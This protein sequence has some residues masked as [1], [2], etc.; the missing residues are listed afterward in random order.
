MA[1]FYEHLAASRRTEGCWPWAGG[2]HKLGYGHASIPGPPRKKGMAHRM[3]Y[4]Y[5]V[6]PI[7]PGMT[8]DHLCYNRGCVNPAHMRL[9]SQSENVRSRCTA[10]SASVRSGCSHERQTNERGN[11]IPCA[12]CSGASLERYRERYPDWKARNR[13]AS[14]KYKAKLKCGTVKINEPRPRISR[15]TKGVPLHGEVIRS[16]VRGELLDGKGL[17]N[18]FDFEELASG[19]ELGSR[20][21]E[22]AR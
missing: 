10:L 12:V 20:G 9:V 19:A 3:V 4:E 21:F 8:I 15:L 5:L 22:E 14:A 13:A 16:G 11:L 17:D 1:I 6:G 18:L 7:P 2:M